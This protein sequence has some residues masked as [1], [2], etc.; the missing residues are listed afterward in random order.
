MSC[1]CVCQGHGA[2]CHRWRDA[3]HTTLRVTPCP[4]PAG[5]QSGGHWTVACVDCVVPTLLC[6][7]PSTRTTAWYHSVCRRPAGAH[8]GV[9]HVA[10]RG[11][12]EWSV[13]MCLKACIAAQ[14]TASPPC[15]ASHTVRVTLACHKRPSPPPS[16]TVNYERGCNPTRPRRAPPRLSLR[17]T[18]LIDGCW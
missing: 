18:S 8:D 7:T 14:S 16:F 15:H 10:A 11:A 1:V 3:R 17:F 12:T 9:C 6:S 13:C 4:T 2:P 5:S